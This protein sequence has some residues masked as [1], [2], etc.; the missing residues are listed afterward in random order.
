MVIFFS[1]IFILFIDLHKAAVITTSVK[2]IIKVRPTGIVECDWSKSLYLSL[3]Q[4][5]L[6][7]Q[8]STVAVL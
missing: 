1:F 2:T 8:P 7:T 3:L 4:S 5:M 6:R